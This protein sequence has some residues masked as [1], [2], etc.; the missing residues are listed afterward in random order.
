VSR[1]RPRDRDW[2]S[3]ERWAELERQTGGRLIKVESPWQACVEAPGSAS[4]AELFKELRNPYYIGDDVALTQTTGWV[5]A[6]TSQPSVYAVAARS[7][8]DVVAAV[9]FARRH[10]L[11]LVVKG[12]GHSYLGTSNAPDSLLV[13]MR[14][15]N[16]ITLHDAFV[17]SGCGHSHAPQPAVTLGAGAIWMHAYDRV[18]T[19]GGRYVQGGGCGTVGVAGLVLGGGFGSYSKKFGTAASSLLEA[20]IVTADGNVRIANACTNP[21]LFW[22]LKGGGGGTFGVVTRLTLRT[23]A[24]PAL[25]GFVSAAIHASSALSFRR[26]VGRFLD[27]YADRLHDE[28][29]G[30]IAAIRS[31]H[32]LDIEMTSQGL[33]QSQAEAL[34]RP[35]F[36]WVADSP[37]DFT[38]T[39]AP[40]IRV[41]PGVHRWDAAYIRPRAPTAMTTDDRPGA[42][43]ENV[44]WS[45]NLAEAG[46]FIH[47]YES[48]WLP[49]ALL[50][51]KRAQLAD[52][53]VAAAAHST[54]ELHF[55]KGL[56]GGAQEAIAAAK[57]TSTNPAMIDAFVLAIIGREGPPAYPGIRGHE[58]DLGQAR[59]NADAVARAM[60]ELRRIAPE[61]GSYVLESSFFERDWQRSYWGTNY[62]R[63]LRIKREYDPGGL[64]FARHGVGSE[65]WSDDGFTRLIEG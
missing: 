59:R 46:H 21:E 15:I 35:F 18:T 58:P 42:P 10:D 62:S 1:V 9:N 56:A 54:V 64:F 5:D 25:F 20:E 8:G 27:L 2:P 4:C 60:K 33:D 47:G 36:Q 44:F 14:A 50:E 19:K 43:A 30:E 12:G 28:H 17:A 37:R 49:A 31:G 6:W 26:L 22:A 55:Q 34:W 63:L 11:R 51:G 3:A 23:H 57:E 65:D 52:A 61:A 45:A 29:W 13:W 53:L 7:A 24:L 48:A 32:R 40:S 38:F 39:R 41:L 16:D